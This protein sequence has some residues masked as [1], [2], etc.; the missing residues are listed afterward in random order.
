VP[1]ATSNESGVAKSV[2]PKTCGRSDGTGK[3]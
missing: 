3:W 1:K 2:V